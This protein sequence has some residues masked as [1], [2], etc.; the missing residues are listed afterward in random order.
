M[1]SA[2]VTAKAFRAGFHRMVHRACPVPL[3]S[4]PRVTRYSVFR[5]AGWVQEPWHLW[6]LCGLQCGVSSGAMKMA[7]SGHGLAVQVAWSMGGTAREMLLA[8][9]GSERPL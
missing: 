4:M 5:A 1:R 6:L 9:E 8:A 2:K 3:G 7:R